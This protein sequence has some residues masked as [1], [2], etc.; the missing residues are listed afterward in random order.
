MKASAEK[1]SPSVDKEILEG[2][3]LAILSYLS[4][5]C[6]IPLVIKKDNNL[7]VCQNDKIYEKKIL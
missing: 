2:K 6:I 4:I 3:I 5:L 1:G 7:A